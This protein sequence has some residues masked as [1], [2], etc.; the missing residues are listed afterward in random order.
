MSKEARTAVFLTDEQIT[1]GA[2]AL[3]RSM[4]EACGIDERD[5]WQ[6]YAETFK[7]DAK[8][9]LEAAIGAGLERDIRNATLEE[10]AAKIGKMPFG[11]TAASFAVW[12][13]EQKT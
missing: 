11:D 4:A 10:I 12:I 2:R 7:E 13:R 3:C 5:Q 1:A 6:L 8:T 9:V